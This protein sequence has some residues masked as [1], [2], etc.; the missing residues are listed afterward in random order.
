MPWPPNAGSSA[1]WTLT[2]LPSNRCDDL[3]RHELEIAGERNELDLCW[4]RR[5]SSAAF[6]GRIR[7][8]RTAVGMSQRRARSSAPACR[9]I[10]R[11]DHDVPASRS[12]SASKW[13]RMACRFDPPPDAS[14]AMRV[15]IVADSMARATTREARRGIGRPPRRANAPSDPRGASALTILGRR[16]FDVEQNGPP[17]ERD[18]RL[19]VAP[20]IADEQRARSA[21]SRTPRSLHG[22]DRAPVCGSRTDL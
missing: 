20:S 14:T 4:S 17:S 9:A 15:V 5:S 3:V 7:C 1:G 8:R 21:R 16:R 2:I 19:D 12:P 10:A 6:A 22:R 13:S 18:S 11:D